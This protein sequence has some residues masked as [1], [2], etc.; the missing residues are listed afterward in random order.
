MSTDEVLIECD[1]SDRPMRIM[2]RVEWNNYCEDIKRID[3][4]TC[5]WCSKQD[6]SAGCG[7]ID[8]NDDEDVLS[9]CT[10]TDITSD[11]GLVMKKIKSSEFNDLFDLVFYNIWIDLSYTKDDIKARYPVMYKDFDF[12]EYDDM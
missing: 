6:D 10:V 5:T 9:F 4:P 8:L 2:T 11:E 7:D 1:I 3:Y 12:D